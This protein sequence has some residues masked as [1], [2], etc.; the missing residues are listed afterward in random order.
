MVLTSSTRLV[1]TGTPVVVGVSGL[2]QDFHAH[3]VFDTFRVTFTNP[4]VAS[5]DSGSNEWTFR[6]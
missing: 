5:V 1:G 4:T 6:W 3:A 2:R